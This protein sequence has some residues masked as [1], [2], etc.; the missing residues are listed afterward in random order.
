MAELALHFEFTKNTD[1]DRATDAVRE[2][3]SALQGVEGID[4]VREQPR[5][6]G[7]EI[8][9][10]IA[11]TVQIVRG[12]RRLLE[13]IRRLVS[14]M[15]SLISEINGLQSITVE[16]G[17]KRVAIAEVNEDEMRQIAD[18]QSEG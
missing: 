2:R 1:I 7:L 13:E 12:T 10:A 18:D 15:K 6:T 8:A 9:A 4:A 3:L 11:V 17:S 14:E 5:L 16:V